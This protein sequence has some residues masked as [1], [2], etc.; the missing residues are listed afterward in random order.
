MILT[1]RVNSV[2][3]KPVCLYVSTAPLWGDHLS[4]TSDTLS[5]STWA[6]SRQQG[7]NTDYTRPVWYY[8]ITDLSIIFLFC[9]DLN[10]SQCNRW[11]HQVHLE[12]WWSHSKYFRVE[13]LQLPEWMMT[14]FFT[15]DALQSV[16][17]TSNTGDKCLC[18]SDRVQNYCFL[19]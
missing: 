12:R 3:T 8:T 14:F 2:K 16:F 5:D 4:F 18:L 17:N 15:F 19:N 10:N 11:F 13:F 1:E 9:N 7:Y 6:A